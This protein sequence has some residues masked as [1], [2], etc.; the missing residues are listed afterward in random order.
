MDGDELAGGA[1]D[2]ARLPRRL[3]RARGVLPGR[4]RAPRGRDRGVAVVAA[5]GRGDLY[6]DDKAP[7]EWLTD[8]S[9][10][11]YAIGQR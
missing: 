10:L 8:L 7:V 4:S 5:A 11:R 9:I 1:S 2:R 6:T 3:S